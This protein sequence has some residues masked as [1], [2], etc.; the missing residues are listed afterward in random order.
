[1]K[2]FLQHILSEEETLRQKMG[3]G[4]TGSLGDCFEA[5]FHWALALDED[6]WDASKVCQG[7]VHGQGPL[8]GKMFSHGW[9]ESGGKV[10]DY[11]N[12]KK[13]VMTKNEYYK[14]GKIDESSV[15]CYTIPKAF[16]KSVNKGHYGPWDF[17]GDTVDISEE[18]PLDVRR[19]IGKKKVKI[20]RNI[21]KLL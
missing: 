18:L 1:M 15:Y 17:K 9:G 20:P 16:G 19:G 5:A 3:R 10:Y 7:M 12:K 6:E 14:L 11:S 8:E 4:Y 21:L 2:S 13:L